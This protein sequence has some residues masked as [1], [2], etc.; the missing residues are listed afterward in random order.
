MKPQPLAEN[1]LTTRKLIRNEKSPDKAALL[2]L[3]FSHSV[4]V[5]TGAKRPMPCFPKARKGLRQDS[6]PGMGTSEPKFIPIH[7]L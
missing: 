2:G 1:H 3:W 4:G 7:M 5:G 6:H